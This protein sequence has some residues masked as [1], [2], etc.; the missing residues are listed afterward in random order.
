MRPDFPSGFVLLSCGVTL[1][2]GEGVMRPTLMEYGTEGVTRP[3]N[4][5]VIRPPRD[6]ATDDGRQ[7]GPTVGG[8]SFVAA[9]KTPQSGGHAKYRFLHG[10]VSKYK[11]TEPRHTRR[12][13]KM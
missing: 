3:E 1:P 6:D 11:E 4:E 10:S 2:N 7:F 8:E 9:T 12:R 13:G 5:G